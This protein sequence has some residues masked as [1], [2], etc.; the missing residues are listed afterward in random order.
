[1]QLLVFS[2]N[3]P[4]SAEKKAQGLMGDGYEKH[5]SAYKVR[6]MKAS[7]SRILRPMLMQIFFVCSWLFKRT[8]SMF[9]PALTL[10]MPFSTQGCPRM[11]VILT[12]P[13]PELI[14][15][16]LFKPGTIY[17]CTTPCYGLREA[18]KLWEEARDKT[19]T[20]FVFQIDGDE[21]SLRQ[22]TYHPS[23]WFV[24]HAPRLVHPRTVRLQDDSD[25]P[26]ISAFTNTSM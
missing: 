11:I 13:A 22:S 7:K 25:L 2:L 9:W 6:I 3:K 18:P 23:M 26:D 5:A 1:M 19:L 15:F 16:G 14:Q 21:Y 4:M 20:S 24:V 17:Q 12:Q 10:A 8:R